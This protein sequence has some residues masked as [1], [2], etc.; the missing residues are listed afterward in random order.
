MTDE[1]EP[2]FLLIAV[3]R[4]VRLHSP[5]VAATCSFIFWRSLLASLLQEVF[6]GKLSIFSQIHPSQSAECL[7]LKVALLFLL[8]TVLGR[9]L[10]LPVNSLWVAMDSSAPLCT[11]AFLPALTKIIT[12]NNTMA[13]PVTCFLTMRRAVSEP[14]KEWWF[15]WPYPYHWPDL[16][17]IKDWAK[18]FSTGAREEPV[19]NL[20]CCSFIRLRGDPRA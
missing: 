20:M 9:L 7:A 5:C 1:S 12:G 14:G 4:A 6:P 2:F 13:K 15:F 17:Q 11:S 8:V 19:R 3:T 18:C 10:L 16:L